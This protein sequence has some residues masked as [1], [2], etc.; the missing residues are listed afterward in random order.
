MRHIRVLICQVDDGTPDL[1]NELACFDLATYALPEIGRRD[2]QWP[3]ATA[4]AHTRG[5]RTSLT[6]MSPFKITLM[7]CVGLAWLAC[8]AVC[9]TDEARGDHSLQGEPP[10]TA[11]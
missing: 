4:S 6:T 3:L 8:R 11:E 9:P 7:L 10:C 1:M 5:E 2:G